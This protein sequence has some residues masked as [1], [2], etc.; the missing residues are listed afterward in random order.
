MAVHECLPAMPNAER[1]HS[2]SITISP[3]AIAV[4]NES[5]LHTVLTNQTQQKTTNKMERYTL[6][7]EIGEGSFGTVYLAVDERTGNQ[8]RTKLRRQTRVIRRSSIS[9]V[10]S[11]IISPIIVFHFCSTSHS[12]RLNVSSTVLFNTGAT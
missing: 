9:L 10:L 4:D 2:S 6:G 5:P 11:K 8:V 12:A 3:H 7:R 1:T